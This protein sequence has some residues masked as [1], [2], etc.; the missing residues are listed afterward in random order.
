M[1]ETHVY[2]HTHT[3]VVTFYPL[4][5]AQKIFAFNS[6]YVEIIILKSANYNSIHFL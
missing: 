5:M 4:Y 2:A 1:I 6:G 3:R